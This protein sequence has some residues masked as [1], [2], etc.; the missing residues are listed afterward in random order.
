ME[1]PPENDVCSI[2]HANFHIPCQANCS[3]WFCGLG[4][5]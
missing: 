1:R 2:C 5:G 3:H 4:N